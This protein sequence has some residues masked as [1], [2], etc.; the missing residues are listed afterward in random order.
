MKTIVY[1]IDNKIATIAFNPTFTDK[2]IS[3]SV[4]AM[5]GDEV[6]TYLKNTEDIPSDLENYTLDELGEFVLDT[7]KKT[8]SDA[9]IKIIELENEITPRRIRESVLTDDGLT[10]LQS[11]ENEIAIE[12]AKL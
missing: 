7:E 9:L 6:I 12:R 4:S 5:L 1:T 2:Q 3:I 8:K 11:K 10:W